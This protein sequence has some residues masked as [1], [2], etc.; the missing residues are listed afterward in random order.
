[1]MFFLKWHADNINSDLLK[2]MM[3]ILIRCVEYQGIM[4]TFS[5]VVKYSSLHKLTGLS[6]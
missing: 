5:E 3:Q 1:M 2:L 4:Y 6:N